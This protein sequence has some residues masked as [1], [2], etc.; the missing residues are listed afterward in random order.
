MNIEE[1]RTYC[2]SLNFV[3]EEF[4]FDDVSLVFKVAGKM[5]ALL[6]L[7]T[8]EKSISLKCN[9]EK[10]VELRSQYDFVTPGYHFN[11]KH[12]N[13]VYITPELSTG[14]LK[15]WILHSYN[16]VVNKFPKAKRNQILG[17]E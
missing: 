8:V 14:L 2:L 3:T 5:F 9:P 13:T 6:P 4:P 10:A 16:E 7:D 17:D 11:K 12:W 1:I 15:E